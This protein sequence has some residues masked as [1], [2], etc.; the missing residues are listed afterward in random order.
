MLTRAFLPS[1]SVSPTRG[2]FVD[3]LDSHILICPVGN[4]GSYRDYDQFKHLDNR[5]GI[6]E[7]FIKALNN[8]FKETDLLF[9]LS[10]S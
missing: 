9:T 2:R 3:V 7:S 10:E 8:Q 5:A 1:L 4:G 6:R